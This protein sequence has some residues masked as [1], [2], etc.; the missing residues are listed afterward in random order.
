[1][2]LVSFGLV[3]V[4]SHYI[5]SCPV[6]T[7]LVVVEDL[8]TWEQKLLG[9]Q[10]THPFSSYNAE[11][12]LFAFSPTQAPTQSTESVM[13]TIASVSSAP[14]YAPSVKAAGDFQ[15]EVEGEFSSNPLIGYAVLIIGL[16][17]A[18]KILSYLYTAVYEMCACHTCPSLGWIL[19][20]EN[21]S[22][23]AAVKDREAEGL[24]KSGAQNVKEEDD[25]LESATK[26]K[27]VEMS[28]EVINKF[29]M[30]FVA[31]EKALEL[32][33]QKRIEKESEL[34]KVMS[35]L[36]AAKKK[37]NSLDEEIRSIKEISSGRDTPKGMSPMAKRSSYSSPS[38]ESASKRRQ[39]TLGRVQGRN[40]ELFSPPTTGDG[41]NDEAYNLSSEF[42]AEAKN[43]PQVIISMLQHPDGVYE[44][45]TID[46]MANGTGIK[47]YTDKWAGQIY[48]GSWRNNRSHGQG[49]LKWPSGAVYKGEWRNGRI[50]GKGQYFFAD[51]AIYDGEMKDGK[52]HGYGK[53]T[54]VDGRTYEGQFENDKQHG[55]GVYR[56]RE[57]TVLYKGQYVNGKRTA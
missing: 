29:E 4:S 32:E 23:Y 50:E 27:V 9:E 30:R 2:L 1:M 42:A 35:E 48:E 25:D 13:P 43:K 39:S 22:G 55:F 19:G 38:T 3:S 10:E 45:E 5:D 56:S 34:N 36:D 24:M 47:K 54:Y 16:I 15:S 57:G 12:T 46:G 7:S 53:Y 31:L 33:R 40:N 28:E 18:L 49:S 17:V 44:G 11:L 14:T 41:N 26:P 8:I 51:G 37:Y 21:Q 20:F 52:S 6:I